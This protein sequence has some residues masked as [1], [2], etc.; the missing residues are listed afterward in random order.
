[1]LT[2]SKIQLKQN[3]IVIIVNDNKYYLIDLISMFIKKNN[4]TLAPD[5][6]ALY[7]TDC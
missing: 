6:L 3:N 1:M 5:H 2:Y 4:F 7:T